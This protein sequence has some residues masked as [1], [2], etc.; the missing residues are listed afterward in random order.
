MNDYYYITNA[1]KCNFQKR[2]IL[3][4][5]LFLG[6]IWCIGNINITT[7][8]KAI[9]ETGR[10]ATFKGCQVFFHSN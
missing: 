6:S 5:S 8:I 1:L 7:D 2:I 4:G 9:D 10:P 3:K